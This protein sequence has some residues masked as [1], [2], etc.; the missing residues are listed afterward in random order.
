[1]TEP[2]D[3]DINKTIAEFMGWID[4]GPW[5]CDNKKEE[6]FNPTESLDALIP[7]VDKLDLDTL[8]I[9]RFGGNWMILIE[10]EDQFDTET[11]H[12]SFSRALALACYEV[13]KNER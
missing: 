12:E 4:I 2:R 6:Y 3:E 7:V 5:Y 8:Q 13:L 10:K 9:N 1:M 11:D